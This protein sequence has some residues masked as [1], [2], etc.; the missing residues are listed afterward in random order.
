MPCALASAATRMPSTPRACA[1]TRRPAW[2]AIP[3][4]ARISSAVNWALSGS[5]VTVMLP[6]VAITLMTSAPCSTS[7]PVRRVTSGTPWAT[8]PRK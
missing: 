2:F 5:E 1:V 8:P 4:I 3:T 7:S 6:P